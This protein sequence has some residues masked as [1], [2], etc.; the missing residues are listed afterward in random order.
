MD[1]IILRGHHLLCT[2]LFSGNGYNQ[3][4]TEHMKEIVVRT[5]VDKHK[6]FGSFPSAKEL[7]LICETDDICGKCPN[8]SEKKKGYCILG[9]ED[10]QKKDR[11]TLKYSGLLENG[12]YTLQEAET[13]IKQISREQFKEICSSCRW[14]GKYCKYEELF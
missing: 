8:F 13:G 4:F 2:R 3:A 11:L 9:N 6:K 7:L 12:I 1:R 10:V 14:Y 5:G